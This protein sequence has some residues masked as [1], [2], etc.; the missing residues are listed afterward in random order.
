LTN[1]SWSA[2][3]QRFD[4]ASN[5]GQLS[6]DMVEPAL[7]VGHRS[8]GGLRPVLRRSGGAQRL[9][10]FEDHRRHGRKSA[11]AQAT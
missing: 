1:I 2:T 4:L 3:F 7:V 9:V 5:C 10:E 11:V 6:I 8:G